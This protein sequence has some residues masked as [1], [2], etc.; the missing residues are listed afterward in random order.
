MNAH[1]IFR[2]MA[3]FACV[4]VGA[5]CHKSRP[6]AGQA[7]IVGPDYRMGPCEGGVYINIDSHPN[8]KDPNGNYDIGAIPPSFRL[9][10]MNNIH[11]FPVRVELDWTIVAACDTNIVDI[12]RINRLGD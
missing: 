9:D 5:G 2:L 11:D 8:H 7:T 1:V 6:Y 3:I 12:T 10:T 4:L